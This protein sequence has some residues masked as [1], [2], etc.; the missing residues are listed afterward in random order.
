VVAFNEQVQNIEKSK[1]S[2]VKVLSFRHCEGKDPIEAIR[3]TYQATLNQ[4]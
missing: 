2:L 1:G 3:C 4:Y